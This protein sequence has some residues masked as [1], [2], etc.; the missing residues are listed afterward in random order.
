MV[1]E[2][3]SLPNDHSARKSTHLVKASRH[4]LHRDP[5]SSSHGRLVRD[6]GKIN[7]LV[8]QERLPDNRSTLPFHK[9][10]FAA[11][12]TGA[13]NG[14]KLGLSGTVIHHGDAET[15]KKLVGR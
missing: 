3:G 12:V 9:D 8:S 2:A 5:G 6:E 11:F 10:E 4:T 15:H 14:S 1:I 13:L 7:T